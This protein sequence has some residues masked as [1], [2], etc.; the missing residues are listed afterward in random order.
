MARV[1]KLI[2]RDPNADF[3][4]RTNSNRYIGLMI[5]RGYAVAH[6]LR[7]SQIAGGDVEVTLEDGSTLKNNVS[8]HTGFLTG[9]AKIAGTMVQQK[10]GRKSERTYY[11]GFSAGGFLGRLVQYL[12]GAN[13]GDD[14]QPLFDG[15]LLGDA[16]AGFWLPVL[17]VD[18]KDT[19]FI[20]NETATNS[21]RRSTSPTS[22]MK[23]APADHQSVALLVQLFRM[24]SP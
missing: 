12:P 13:R 17:M 20:G 6:T 3:H 22:S 23:S 18:G 19:L 5:D 8:T 4:P 11:Y 21:S 9:M 2:E 1:G 10:L 15:F 16:G 7:S 14:G 24:A